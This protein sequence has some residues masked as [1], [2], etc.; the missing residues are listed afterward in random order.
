M[1]SSCTT[2]TTTEKGSVLPKI[3]SGI[4]FVF[5]CA[6]CN[7]IIFCSDYSVDNNTITQSKVLKV[8]NAAQQQQQET[9]RTTT[10]T[11]AS[12]DSDNDNTIVSRTVIA[13]TDDDEITNNY[14]VNY[15]A[16]YFHGNN[17]TKH[18]RYRYSTLDEFGTNINNTIEFCEMS[19][20][21]Q[22]VGGHFGGLQCNLLRDATFVNNTDYTQYNNGVTLFNITIPSC[23]DVFLKSFFGTGNYMVAI[24]STRVG[25][26]IIGNID[27]LLQCN[28]AIETQNTLIL[29]WLMGKFPRVAWATTTKIVDSSSPDTTGSTNNKD[30]PTGTTIVVRDVA[31]IPLL[32]RT[33]DPN[34]LDFVCAK[35]HYSYDLPVHIQFQLRRMVVGVLGSTM[36]IQPP[37]ILFDRYV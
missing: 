6:L 19:Q 11:T 22:L 18:G 36:G 7:Y 32:D 13:A 2:T 15:Y 37:V 34:S 30:L 14:N 20:F 28:D 24:M 4:F 26:H 3:Q 23:Y 5:I 31:E 17:T 27:L 10:K 33:N 9:V 21:H 29:P 12:A 8:Q 35:L 1:K 25:A 16:H